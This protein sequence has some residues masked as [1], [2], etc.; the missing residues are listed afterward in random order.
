MRFMNSKLERDIEN[1]C[2]RYA[3]LQGWEHIKLDRA[4]RGWPDRLF[5]GPDGRRLLVEFK[6]PGQKA[7]P[8][9]KA[10]HQRLF[11]LGHPVHLVDHVADFCLLLDHVK[12]PSDPVA[13]Q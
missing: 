13:D 9:Q 6:R 12:P 4:K 10:V 5:L 1:A 2:V 7:R 3:E 11:V 8:L